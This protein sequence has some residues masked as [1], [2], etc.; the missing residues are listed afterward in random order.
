MIIE[1]KRLI[2]KNR[3]KVTWV[4]REVNKCADKL[5]NMA[6]EKHERSL[7]FRNIPDEIKNI[8]DFE[9]PKITF[10]SNGSYRN[11]KV[12]STRCGEK[13]R[14]LIPTSPLLH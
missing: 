1:C 12:I 14:K 8:V 7:V 6:I 10:E 11:R 4:S 3:I 9:S 13:S 5:A 2:H